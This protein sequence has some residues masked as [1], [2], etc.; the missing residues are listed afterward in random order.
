VHGTGPRLKVIHPSP[1]SSSRRGRASRRKG[2][3]A[4]RVLVRFLQGRGLN[5]TKT[6]RT[7]YAGT[8][9]SLDLLGIER[10]V[11]CKVRARAF[12]ALY[13][14]LSNA[15]LLIIRADRREPLCVLPLWLAAEVA[16][17]HD[18]INDNGP[19]RANKDDLNRL[20][21]VEGLL[22]ES[23]N[24]MIN[25]RDR[26]AFRLMNLCMKVHGLGFAPSDECA[27]RHPNPQAI[28]YTYLDYGED[29]W[30]KL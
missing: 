15:D 17:A 11:E 25:R 28:A 2:L 8:D 6:S 22:H 16:A 3:D 29:C 30:D 19:G 1:S 10:R 27:R 23:E 12:G 26:V 21:S 4:E 18:V 20:A 13:R 24:K 5:A 14:W 7:G 9:L